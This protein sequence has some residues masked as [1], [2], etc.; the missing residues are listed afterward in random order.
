MNNMG[1]LT[2]VVSDPQMVCELF[3][4][5]NNLTDKTSDIY[6]M[7]KDLLGESFL[8]SKGDSNWKAKRQA[9]AHAFY[10]DRLQS[11][12]EVFKQI[13]AKF[14]TKWMAEIDASADKSTTL[15]IEEFQKIFGQNMVHIVFGEDIT[16][17]LFELKVPET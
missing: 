6:Q 3:T 7:Y 15:N 10:K 12:L 16:D 4:T 5:K 2:V 1:K 9:C 11:M 8:F 17:Q 14:A 13:F